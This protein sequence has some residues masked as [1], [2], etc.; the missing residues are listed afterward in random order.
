[1]E[2]LK[3][4]FGDAGTALT[5]AVQVRFPI[6]SSAFYIKGVSTSFGWMP[7]V[8]ISKSGIFS[9]KVAKIAENERNYHISEM[10]NV[11]S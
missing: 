4:A 9:Q 11:R 3:R 1:M 2:N 8:N 10:H 7:L 6:T 5:R